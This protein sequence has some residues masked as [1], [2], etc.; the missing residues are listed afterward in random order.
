MCVA[1]AGAAGQHLLGENAV[2]GEEAVQQRLYAFLTN[3][4]PCATP[5]APPLPAL[6]AKLMAEDRPSQV[7]SAQDK[8]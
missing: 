4:L 2:L 1:G 6:Y 5:H 7:L 8:H 3:T